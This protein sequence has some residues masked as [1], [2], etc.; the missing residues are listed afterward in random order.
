MDTVR[1]STP[2][3]P[4][5]RQRCASSS[6]GRFCS[7]I[8]GPGTDRRARALTQRSCPRWRSPSYA[9]SSS[10]S[11]RPRGVF[12]LAT[13]QERLSALDEQTS[14]PDFWDD[15]RAAQ[16]ALRTAEGLRDEIDTWRSLIQRADDLLELAELGRR[17]GR[18]G[19]DGRPRVRAHDADSPTTTGCAPALLFSGP[20]DE[21]NAIVSITAGAGGTEAT[22]W[23]EMLLRMYLRWA[24][25][26]PLRHRDPRS[27]RGRGGRHQ[28]RDHRHRRA[29]R[30]RLPARRA[31]RASPGAHQPVR[32]AEAPPH[33]VR[34]GRGAARGRRTTPRSARS[35]RT[36]CAST[37]SARRVP[38]VSTSTRPIRPCA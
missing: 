20:Y 38:A 1:V 24:R 35:P 36:S 12:D 4:E 2:S 23:A 15:Q 27:A 30:L 37:P 16:Q 8:C 9:T 10:G 22:D 28:E 21:K 29:L 17:V 18:R 6:C 7:R 11:T 3:S 31:R 13:K 26:A 32:L 14:S 25:A 5:A 33:D 34:A 19:D